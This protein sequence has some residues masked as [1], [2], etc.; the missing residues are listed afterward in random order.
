MMIYKNCNKIIGFI[1][2]I[3]IDA[4]YI[5]TKILSDPNL[6]SSSK[7]KS[8]ENFTS[9]ALQTSIVNTDPLNYIATATIY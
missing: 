9:T 4:I 7:N 6:V 8:I 1:N 3:E 5:T 2:N